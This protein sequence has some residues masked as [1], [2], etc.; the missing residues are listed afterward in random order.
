MLTRYLGAAAVAACIASCHA[1]YKPFDVADSCHCAVDHYCRISGASPS[2][3]PT[4]ECVAIP[5][6]CDPPSC[7]CVGRPV[8]ACREELGR[9]WVFARRPV[10]GCD[11]CSG[12]EYC[13]STPEPARA[14]RHECG[15]L[16]PQCEEG[17]SCGC[18]A[19]LQRGP[20]AVT[21]SESGGRVELSLASPP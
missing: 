15:L 21:C 18:L 19:S 11:Q 20:G 13:L 2:A 16:P 8:D 5:A 3:P 12:E 6:T 7:S 10:V 14:P 4:T 1:S 17:A 9:I